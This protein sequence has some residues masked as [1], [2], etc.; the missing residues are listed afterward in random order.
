MIVEEKFE[1]TSNELFWKP[2]YENYKPKQAIFYINNKP[3][4]LEKIKFLEV[5]KYESKTLLIVQFLKKRYFVILLL[6]DLRVGE[7]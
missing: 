1:P 7:I 5:F 2:P 4:Q 6:S 3:T